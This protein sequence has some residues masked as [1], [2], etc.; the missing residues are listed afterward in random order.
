MALTESPQ[1]F[2]HAQLELLKMFSRDLPEE[3]W[4]ELRRIIAQYFMQKRLSW[5][6]K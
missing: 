3:Q 6:I 4:T 1:R 2:T 5:R